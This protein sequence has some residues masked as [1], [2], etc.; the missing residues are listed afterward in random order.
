MKTNFLKV[1]FMALAATVIASCSQEN[2]VMENIAPEETTGQTLKIKASAAGFEA[3]DAQTR[4]T[5][6]GATTVFE[7]GDRM[8]LYIIENYG[9]EDAEAELI[10]TVTLTY[11]GST[12]TPST[13]VYVYDNA[14]Y[15]AY[16]PYNA[17]FKPSDI[18]AL[19]D[20]L[21]ATV[22][23]TADQSQNYHD[24]DLM[25]AK[26]TTAE[27]T[28]ASNTLNLNLTHT[29]AMIEFSIPV[30]KYSC[31]KAN[32]TTFE[33]SIPMDDIKF[34][35]GDVEYTP[36]KVNESTY[37]CL[38]TPAASI[39]VSGSFMDPSDK[40]PVSFSNGESP[41]SLAANNY[42]RYNVTYDGAP[43]ETVKDLG[44]IE[45]GDYLLNNGGILKPSIFQT[46]PASVVGIVYSVTT[47]DPTYPNG[48]AVALKD[49]N[50][51]IK[52]KYT[53]NTTTATN[54]NTAQAFTTT[55]W[56]AEGSLYS[57]FFSTKNGLALCQAALA[58][59]N[60][61]EAQAISMAVEYNETCP[62]TNTSGWYLPSPGE[63]IEMF[64][65]LGEQDILDV[66]TVSIISNTDKATEKGKNYETI[67]EKMK[68]AGG[69]LPIPDPTVDKSYYRWWTSAEYDDGN[70][71]VFEWKTNGQISFINR[72]KKN[73]S[74]K[75]SI[76]PFLAF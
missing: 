35:I 42:I 20:E 2:E 27:I 47:T 58:S 68:A 50:A 32:S 1:S 74:Q 62:T 67:I 24:L 63:I 12:W 25:I 39:E 30:Y 7:N 6:N 64:N 52:G 56:N 55:D 13:P 76:R 61:S 49:V 40:R 28:A 75:Q 16:F 59:Q 48:Y 54:F 57:T 29:A 17:N 44:A 69:E 60:S 18:N 33:Y 37:R 19:E 65:A 45:V 8:G 5:D 34:S 10:N 22:I 3:A 46:V 15:V 4:A 21:K 70:V 73:D 66:T 11:D 53:W 31:I 9:V 43:A 38:V 14:T 72:P 23:L 26:Q 41:A 36:Y 71:W 51:D